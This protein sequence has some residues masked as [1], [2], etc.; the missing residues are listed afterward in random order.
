MKDLIWVFGYGSLI[1]RPD[2]PFFEARR[3]Y[4]DGWQRRF[5]QGSHDHRG[6]ATDPGRVVT[7]IEAGGA[8][9]Y[10]RAYLIGPGV[11]EH[12]DRRESNGYQRHRVRIC[13]DNGEAVGVMYVATYDNLAYLGD[14]PLEDMVK[15]IRRAAGKS[16]TNV[17][18]VLKL[19]SALRELGESDDHVF[20]L[21]ER[22][23]AG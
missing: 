20:E 2:F 19:A 13:F 16:G 4:V 6:V 12:L 15:Q 17:E 18:Y 7:L 23:R 22:L 14:A 10:G 11:F 3:A 21:E 1:W 9:C 5:W 8:R